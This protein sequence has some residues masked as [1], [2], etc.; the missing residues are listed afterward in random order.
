MKKRINRINWIFWAVLILA[1]AG[2]IIP[3]LIPYIAEA[4]TGIGTNQIRNSAITTP[5]LAD[6][7]VTETK[8]DI[9]TYPTDEQVLSYDET[10]GKMKWVTGGGDGDMLKSV[11]DLDDDG[12]VDTAEDLSIPSQAAGDILYFDGANW[13]RLVKDAGKYLKSG[14]SAVSWDT[15]AGDGDMTKA[16][17]DL[18]D[19]GKTD[20]AED[21]ALPSQAAGDVI[22][23]DGSNWVRLAKD[24]GKYLKSGDSSVS[25]DTPAGSGD[26]EKATYDT[27]TNDI[28]DDVDDWSVYRQV[29]SHEVSSDTVVYLE[30]GARV[31]FYDLTL[32]D[33]IQV[34]TVLYNGAITPEDGDS[35]IFRVT[36]GSPPKTVSFLEGGA[37]TFAY[38]TTITSTDITQTAENKTDLIGCQYNTAESRWLIV[39][40]SKGF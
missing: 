40:Y 34:D 22:Y 7:S 8:L 37:G 38:G 11:Y 3:L 30:N 35:L 12:K 18:D 26:M 17:Y 15:P 9:D 5:K 36:V 24:S 20:T 19:D 29:L 23:F 10:T 39:A 16:V 14:A 32:T 4:Q 28:V 33:D 2:V 31:S 27:D 21:L 6:G 13:I 1:L 25:W